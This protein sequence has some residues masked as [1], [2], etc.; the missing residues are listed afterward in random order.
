MSDIKNAATKS[1]L[2][3]MTTEA[4]RKIIA[5]KMLSLAEDNKRLK[6]KVCDDRIA[7]H[8]LN[9]LSSLLVRIIN[10]NYAA[11]TESGVPMDE[12]SKR[13]IRALTAYRKE[14]FGYEMTTR[15][16]SILA[17]TEGDDML[18]HDL[19]GNQPSDGSDR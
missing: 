19:I 6:R 17:D 14:N 12:A 9:E 11:F 16:D 13:N 8:A 1:I 5:A 18:L 3:A 15:I 10:S 7:V 4:G 2:A